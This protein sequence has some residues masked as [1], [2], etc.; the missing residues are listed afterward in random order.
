ME[1]KLE[2]ETIEI[3]YAIREVKRLL[4]EVTI[5]NLFEE[6]ILNLNNPKIS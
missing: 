6:K 5:I 2:Q 4:S 1:K 3:I